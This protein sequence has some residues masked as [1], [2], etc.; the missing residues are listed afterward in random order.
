M[1]F[2]W[3]GFIGFI[4]AFIFGKDIGTVL[5]LSL[6]PIVAIVVIGLLR[7]Q[8]APPA[9]LDKIAAETINSVISQFVNHFLLDL[10]AYIAGAIVGLVGS[11]LAENNS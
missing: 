2:F 6:L 8:F 4:I 5:R 11:L 7:M 9:E 10:G 3:L 1:E